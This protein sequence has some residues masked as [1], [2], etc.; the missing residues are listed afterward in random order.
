MLISSLHFLKWLSFSGH[1]LPLREHLFLSL[2]SSCFSSGEKYHFREDC[3]YLTGLLFMPKRKSKHGEHPWHRLSSGLTARAFFGELKLFRQK[4]LGSPTTCLWIFKQY[5][6]A[7]LLFLFF[8]NV[9]KWSVCFHIEL[10]MLTRKSQFCFNSWFG[11]QNA[12]NFNYLHNLTIQ[13]IP[14]VGTSLISTK[15]VASFLVSFCYWK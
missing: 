7:S 12:Q 2:L 3:W 14:F 13:K 6:K 1:N 9:Y 11:C 8:P 4:E 5:F 15:Y 10:S